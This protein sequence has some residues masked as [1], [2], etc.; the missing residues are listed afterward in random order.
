ML[1][2]FSNAPRFT[3][4]HHK[5]W[6]ILQLQIMGTVTPCKHYIFLSSLGLCTQMKGLTDTQPSLQDLPPLARV[7]VYPPLKDPLTW[8]VITGV[9]LLSLHLVY[10]G[11]Q[12]LDACPSSKGLN[13]HLPTQEMPGVCVYEEI[14]NTP[15]HHTSDCL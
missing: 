1:E 7:C 13:H 15:S 8:P 5:C 12:S 2:N 10:K 3:L 4:C 11:L 14:A 9:A 6:T